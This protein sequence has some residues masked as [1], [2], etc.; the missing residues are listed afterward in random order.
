MECER[1]VADQAHRLFVAAIVFKLAGRDETPTSGR[2][3]EA[4]QHLKGA[5]ASE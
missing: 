4:R 5:A 3:R 2:V 1:Y